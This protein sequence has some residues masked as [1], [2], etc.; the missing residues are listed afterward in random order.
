MFAERLDESINHFVRR[1]AL[2]RRTYW[3]ARIGVMALGAASTVLL[4]LRVSDPGY[5]DWSRNLVLGFT[6]LATFL[7]GLG[8]F[9]N[10]EEY[11]VRR[12]AAEHQLRL[13]KERLEYART[14]PA[15]L[16]AAELDQLF[17]EYLVVLRSQG[18]Y[19]GSQAELT[20]TERSGAPAA[21]RMRVEND[22]LP[23]HP[24]DE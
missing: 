19:W 17:E 12:K 7:T 1:N 8:T 4:G 23:T 6:A 16:P 11:W 22:D 18:E 10:L 20:T 2:V 21:Q 13:L 3:A 14:A 24:D 5:A 15:G 9:W